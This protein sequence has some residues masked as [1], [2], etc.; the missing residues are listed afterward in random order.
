MVAISSIRAIITATLPLSVI[1]DRLLTE[2]R[3]SLC[4]AKTSQRINGLVR[5]ELCRFTS[6]YLNIPTAAEISLPPN[7]SY[8]SNTIPKWFRFRRPVCCRVNHIYHRK[9]RRTKY[10]SKH[11]E[12]SWNVTRRFNCCCP[13]STPT[14]ARGSAAS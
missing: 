9:I 7:D 3:Y 8:C 10:V 4:V 6:I 13:S 5:L 12:Q 2:T 1:S 11:I 14:T